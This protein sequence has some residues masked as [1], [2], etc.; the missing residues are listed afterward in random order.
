MEPSCQAACRAFGS[1]GF[2]AAAR[3][4]TTRN[5]DGTADL[6]VA[7]IGTNTRTPCR[8]FNRDGIS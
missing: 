6:V 7:P 3:E 1:L 8:A 2:R 5:G 4:G